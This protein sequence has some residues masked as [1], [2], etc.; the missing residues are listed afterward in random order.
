M[1]INELMIV[2]APDTALNT[3][4][5][6]G[7]IYS[8]PIAILRLENGRLSWRGEN[9]ELPAKTRL[10]AMAEVVFVGDNDDFICQN[11]KVKPIAIDLNATTHYFGNQK[12]WE[13]L[14]FEPHDIDCKKNE[15]GRLVAAQF[16]HEKD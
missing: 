3:D 4:E 7:K 15:H 8:F 13:R 5:I 1:R 12:T 14:K 10:V 16:V 2:R 9:Q 6:K 11:F